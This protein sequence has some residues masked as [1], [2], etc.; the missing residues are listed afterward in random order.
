MLE[1]FEKTGELISDQ[2]NEE[3]KQYLQEN[4]KSV[5]VIRVAETSIT[6]IITKK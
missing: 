1:H 2:L 3:E 6:S 4:I 5:E